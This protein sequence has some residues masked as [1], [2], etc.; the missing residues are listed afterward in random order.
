MTI[1]QNIKRLRKAHH[2][3][4]E[5]LGKALGEYTSNAV[6]QWE[7]DRAVPRMGAI[8]AMAAHWGVS[9]AQ[10]VDE[11]AIALLAVNTPEERTLLLSYRDLDETGRSKLIEYA[12]DLLS[13]GRYARGEGTSDSLRSA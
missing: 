9:K 6:S 2:E 10:I 3:T 7:N 13:S 12:N 4:Q 1:G 11:T 5:A 8:E